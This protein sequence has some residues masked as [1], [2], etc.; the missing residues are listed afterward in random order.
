MRINLEGQWNLR[1]CGKD[2]IF[3][4]EVPGDVYSALLEHGKI[5]DPFYADNEARVQ[6]VRDC[7]WEYS[8]EFMI[9]SDVLEHESVFLN[10]DCI[11]TFSEV[12]INGKKAGKTENMFLRYRFDVKKYLKPG[13]NIISVKIFSAVKK[14]EAESRRQPFPVMWTANNKVPHMNLIR[15]VQCHAGWDWGICMVAAGIYSDIYLDAVN[16]CRIEHVYTSQKHQPDCCN[17]K[18]SVELYAVRS[19]KTGISA[20]LGD[21]TQRK[22]IMLSQG[23]NTID[24]E[25]EVKNPQLWFPVGYGNQPLYDLTVSTVDETVEKRIGLRKLELISEDDDIGRSMYFKVNGIPVF[26]KGANWIPVDAFP[27]RQTRDKY[28]QLLKDA[29]AA[30]MNMLRVWGGGQYEKDCFYEL[31]DEMGILV[32]QDLMFACAEYPSTDDFLA[33]ICREV[34]YQVKRLRDYACIALICG[35]NEV[36]VLS[37][38]DTDNKS[39]CLVNYDRRNSA[40]RNA[41]KR[42][43]ENRPF[44]PG[45]PS[46][47]PFDFDNLRDD[48]KGD[49]HNWQVWFGGKKFDG[50]YDVTPRFCSEFGFQ[51][52]PG[53]KTIAAFAPEDQRNV[54]APV[55]DYHQRSPSGNSKI[56]E[57]FTRYFRFPEGFDNFLYLSQLQHALAMKTAVEYWRR[58][59]P[60]CMGTLYWQINDLW[61]AISWSSIDCFGR[62]KQLHYHAKRF[63]A[64]VII[65]PF[66]DKNGNLD[67]WITN[68]LLENFTGEL[69]AALYDFSGSVLKNKTVKVNVPRQSAKQ[70][71]KYKIAELAPS[72]NDCFLYLELVDADGIT[73]HCNEHFFTEYKNCELP[74]TA[75]SCDVRKASGG[76]WE[77]KLAS[78][79]PAFF[80]ELRAENTDG[81]FSDNSFTLLP[82]REK[83]VEFELRGSVM[84]KPEI[85]VRHLRMTYL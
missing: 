18:V 48:T 6:W 42:A 72:A 16:R 14:A 77:I 82:D 85:S 7:D 84:E 41:V 76:N 13:K 56:I 27:Q 54:T 43:G 24:L 4:A 68:D 69:N 23:I 59:R 31:C 8:R 64:P 17:V 61:P 78:E 70:V 34:E 46:N 49:M 32:W 1:K 57:M 11:D 52:Y 83:I 3:S 22:S 15:K 74:E 21:L 79:A 30:N 80:V 45:S 20:K 51:S 73:V 38:D 36:L 40:L 67:I 62:W 26:C 63:F 37:L 28:E 55:M 29:V 9:E 33:N 12:Y 81:V 58:L 2:E 75:V 60:V 5:P 50:Y 71:K 44:W 66:Q 19:G 25:F 39:R 10:L 35:D 65:S 47:G 53:G